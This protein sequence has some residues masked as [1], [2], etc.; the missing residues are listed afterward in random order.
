[1]PDAPQTPP[2]LEDELQGL[3]HLLSDASTIIGVRTELQ[4]QTERL[5]VPLGNELRALHA[6][7]GRLLPLLPVVALLLLPGCVLDLNKLASDLKRPTVEFAHAD[8]WRCEESVKIPDGAKVEECSR[9]VNASR[10]VQAV[11]IAKVEQ[12]VRVG[13][14]VM[15]CSTRA[16]VSDR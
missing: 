16:W 14:S 1:M 12:S 7:I 13:G 6:A 8:Q 15:L 10:E 3:R 9:C 11:S 2:S 5:L 4:L